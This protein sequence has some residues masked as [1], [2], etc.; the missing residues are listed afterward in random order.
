M[1]QAPQRRPEDRG[2]DSSDDGGAKNSA[3]SGEHSDHSEVDAGQRWTGNVLILVHEARLV[4]RGE[5]V[6]NP[7][8]PINARVAE[9][10]QARIDAEDFDGELIGSEIEQYPGL[11]ERESP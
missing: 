3:F 2:D 4:A 8:F 7:A 1:S 9:K 10:A 6:E 11:A 5:T